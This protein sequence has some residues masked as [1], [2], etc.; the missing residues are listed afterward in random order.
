MFTTVSPDQ[1][2]K[3]AT[4]PKLRVLKERIE[5]SE[6]TCLIIEK[7][8][9]KQGSDVILVRNPEVVSGQDKPSGH[10]SFFFEHFGDRMLT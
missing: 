9:I 10:D 3:S 1:L 2:P 7:P 5:H 6:Q 4:L 8:A